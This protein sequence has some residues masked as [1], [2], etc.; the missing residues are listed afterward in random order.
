[1]DVKDKVILLTGASE[2]IG[3]ATAL[4][5]GKLGARLAIR[6][7]VF[8]NGINAMCQR[9]CETSPQRPFRCIWFC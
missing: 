6:C 5:L 8:R 9:H 3:K 2:G 1:M 4:L 7:A